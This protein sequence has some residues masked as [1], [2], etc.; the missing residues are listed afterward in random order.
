MLDSQVDEKANGLEKSVTVDVVSL[1]Q[2][3]KFESGEELQLG[4][5][6]KLCQVSS[7]LQADCSYLQDVAA[8]CYKLVHA[9]DRQTKPPLSVS[10][11]SCFC[12]AFSSEFTASKGTAR[13]GRPTFDASRL[14]RS[15]RSSSRQE[16]HWG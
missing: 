10:L 12:P 2:D 16:S 11:A 9:Q 4:A 1:F 8:D 13:S 14:S 15:I 5:G 3:I 7:F 6:Q